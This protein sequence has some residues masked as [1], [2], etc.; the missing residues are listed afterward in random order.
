M[1]NRW[2]SLGDFKEQQERY[3]RKY[4]LCDEN[5]IKLVIIPYQFNCYNKLK[6]E[7]FIRDAIISF[8]IEPVDSV[9]PFTVIKN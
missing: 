7:T 4:R 9:V 5:N 3:Q 2:N 1:D 6:L 8:G